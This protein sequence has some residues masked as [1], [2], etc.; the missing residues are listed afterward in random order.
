MPVHAE[1]AGAAQRPHLERG[2]RADDPR[3]AALQLVQ[4]RRHPHRFEHVEIVV[5]GRAIRAK[6]DRHARAEIA[7]DRGGPAGELHV[8]L[9]IV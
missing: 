4:Q 9:R 2:T 6:T 3:V 7:G 5:A 1:R 8:A